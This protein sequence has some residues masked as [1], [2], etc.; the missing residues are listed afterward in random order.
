MTESTLLRQIGEANKSFLSGS[1]RFLDSAG[2][3]FVVVACI[4]P[5]LTGFLEPA[6]GLPKHRAVVIRT[7]GNQLSERTRDELRSIAVAL[8][9]KNARE[10]LIVGHS[11]CGMS[12]F[13]AADVAEAFRKAGIPRSAFGD[14][15]LRIWFGAF[16]SIRENVIGS[17][18]FLRKSGIVPRD[19][20][21]HGLLLDTDKGTMEVVVDGD[22]V[23]ETAAPSV[24]VSE[25]K[26]AEAPAGTTGKKE[27]APAATPPS[28]PVPPPPAQAQAEPTAKKGPII[29]GPPVTKTEPAVAPPSS[30]LDAALVLRD[31]INR[32]RQNQQ[33]QKA[34][35]DLKA[36]WKQ[37][38][39]PYRVFTELQKIGH[40][41][42]TRYPRLPGALVYLENATRSGHADKIGFGEIMKRILD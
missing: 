27:V 14:D 7:A 11:D 9:V 3:P 38:R 13:S 23:R 32:E 42:E 36:L 25:L 16:G 21:I 19:V 37:E 26:V 29:V 31:F 5:R 39:N 28:V 1:P 24:A 8:Y 35:A 17:T 22:L 4:D 15:D 10:I 20:K 12:T 18:T 40:A 34:V 33:M 41:Y 30:L 6:L 2:E